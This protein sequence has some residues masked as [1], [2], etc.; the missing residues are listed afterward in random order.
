MKKILSLLLLVIMLV[1]IMP[2]IGLAKEYNRTYLVPEYKAGII[3]TSSDY[4]I[5]RWNIATLTKGSFTTLKGSTTNVTLNAGTYVVSGIATYTN[6]ITIN[7]DVNIILGDKSELNITDAVDYKAAIHVNDAYT[8]NIYAQSTGTNMGKLVARAGNNAAG[9]GGEHCNIIINGGFIEAYGDYNGAGIGGGKTDNTDDIFFVVINGGNIYAQGG[10]NGGA[11]I[12]AGKS[13]SCSKI[14]INGGTV[15]AKAQLKSAGIGGGRYN[16]AICDNIIINGGYIKATGQ[17][18]SGGIGRGNN[19]TNCN[20]IEING[21]T[22][23]AKGNRGIW[24][25]DTVRVNK[26]LVVAKGDD[27]DN[28]SE[29]AKY[30]ESTDNIKGDTLDKLV[31]VYNPNSD[32][33]TFEELKERLSVPYIVR[34]TL[35]IKEDITLSEGM[36]V[37]Y[38]GYD[39]TINGNGNKLSAG[40]ASG[41]MVQFKANGSKNNKVVLNDIE[42]ESGCL[43]KNILLF[44]HHS[45]VEAPAIDVTLND[46]TIDHTAAYDDSYYAP[47]VNNGCDIKV[48]GSLDITTGVHSY[49]AIDLTRYYDDVKLSFDSNAKVSFT[50]NRTEDEKTA[51]PLIG[52]DSSSNPGTDTDWTVEN[53]EVANIRYVEANGDRTKNGWDIIPPVVEDSVPVV[54]SQ[55]RIEQY[56]IPTVFIGEDKPEIKIITL[57]NCHKIN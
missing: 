27:K 54:A 25:S 7:G 3:G 6:G 35:N 41:Y 19:Q 52:Y 24:A 55:A 22:I 44:Q 36:E 8:L 23:C 10:P 32:I 15:E 30:R 20:S 57:R 11:G 47:I 14:V 49:C 28:L 33:N 13:T 40:S 21:G 31:Y 42:F 5:L 53:P 16:T 17:G 1:S 50:D 48:T 2:A 43:T 56:G 4:G 12:G 18:T 38:S 9:I 39:I 45:N 34:E 26:D 37:K 46:V 51:E 29:I